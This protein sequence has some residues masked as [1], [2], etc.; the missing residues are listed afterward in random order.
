MAVFECDSEQKICKAFPTSNYSDNFT[1]A[2]AIL[3]QHMVWHA[4]LHLPRSIKVVNTCPCVCY[5]VVNHGIHL[6]A[7]TS[8]LCFR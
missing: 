2:V 3:G 7:T 8:M 6:E 4:F 5:K 1:L